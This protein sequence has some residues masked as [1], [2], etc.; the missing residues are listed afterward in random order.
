MF[1]TDKCRRM[2]DL[3]F[4]LRVA[5]GRQLF[6]VFQGGGFKYLLEFWGK[7]LKWWLCCARTTH[8]QSGLSQGGK[9]GWMVKSWKSWRLK[10]YFFQWNFVSRSLH[11]PGWLESRDSRFVRLTGQ[12]SYLRGV[13]CH[14]QR[15]AT[16]KSLLKRGCFK[17]FHTQRMAREKSLLK[18]GVS[19]VF[20]S[21]IFLLL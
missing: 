5:Q 3:C 8:C 6:E 13:I 14:T 17:C 7:I 20:G 11:S 10:N 9:R 19:N 21:F 12:N 1:K 16:Q 2:Q 18:R 15:M 4:L